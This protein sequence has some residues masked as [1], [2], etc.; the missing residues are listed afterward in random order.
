MTDDAVPAG[1]SLIEVDVSTARIS[2]RAPLRIRPPRGTDY[3]FFRI[4]ITDGAIIIAAFI[5]PDLRSVNGIFVQKLNLA[6]FD[7]I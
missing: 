6:G 5:Q 3:D 2:R 1:Y 4:K 7:T